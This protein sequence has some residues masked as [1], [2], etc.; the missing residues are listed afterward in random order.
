M[1]KK[2]L[3]TLMLVPTFC[4]GL[5]IKVHAEEVELTPSDTFNYSVHVQNNAG[6]DKT[7]TTDTYGYPDS[8]YYWIGGN[9]LKLSRVQYKYGSYDPSVDSP[10][11][12]PETRHT[13]WIS[14]TT[15]VRILRILRSL[16]PTCM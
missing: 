11:L 9:F 14:T 1:W 16:S 8:D 6:L 12:H 15:I 3:L 5:S 13:T 7:L 2:I 10:A 4:M